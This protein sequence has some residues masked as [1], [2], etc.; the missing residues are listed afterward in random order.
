M[1]P[2]IDTL[3]EIWTPG[4]IKALYDLLM[5]IHRNKNK[6]IYIQALEDIVSS[7]E[8]FIHD[9]IEKISTTY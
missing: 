8:L 7:K 9:Y 1:N 2:I 5:L 6:D 4:E 3:R